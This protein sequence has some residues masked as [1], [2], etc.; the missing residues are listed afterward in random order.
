MCVLPGWYWSRLLLRNAGRIERLTFSIGLSLAL[1]PAALAQVRMLNTGVTLVIA[2]LSV[3][4][5]L[6][7]GFAAWVAFGADHKRKETLSAPPAPLPFGSLIALGLALV[8]VLAGDA[9]SWRAFRYT[10]YCWGWIS[11]KCTESGASQHFLILVA[12]LLT[13]AGAWYFVA[14]RRV[15]AYAG[16]T[17]EYSQEEYPGSEDQRPTRKVRYL[18]PAV[19]ALVLV[20]GYLGPV[21]YDW[22]FIR[23]VDQYSHAVMSNLMLSRGQ[24]YPYLIYPPGFHTL[25]AVLSRLSGL[26]PL[27]LYTVLAPALLILPALSCYVLARRLW[28][29]EVGVGAAFFAGLVAC[30]PYFYFNDAMYPNIVGAEFLLVLT[31]AALARLYARP[32]SGSVLLVAVLGSSVVLYHQV[33]SLYEAALLGLIGLLFLPY[34]L[35]HDR[36]RGFA[37][38]ASFVILGALSLL[39][40]WNT[41]DLPGTIASLFGG[42]GKNSTDTAMGMAIGSQAPF[43]LDY[44]IGGI[45]SQPVFWLGFL[46]AILASGAAMLSTDLAQKLSTM[47]LVLWVLLMA[48]GSSTTLDGFPERFG[49][50]LGVPLAIFAAF[51]LVAIMRSISAI[52]GT[53]ALRIARIAVI[54]I[55]VLIVVRVVQNFGQAAVPSWR[56]TMTPEIAA[57]GEWLKDHNTGGNIMVSPQ[58]TQVPSRMMLAMGQYSGMQ[59]YTKHNILRNRDLPPTGPGPLYD[60]LWVMNHPTGEH[61][62]RLLQK[63]RV[64]YIVLYKYMPDRPVTN[65]WRHFENQSSQYRVAFQ[66][67]DV[68]IVAPR[69]SLSE[70]VWP[71][72]GE[73][74][75][76]DD[77]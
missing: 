34:L 5:V 17:P 3:A 70:T 22:P 21:L 67:S 59:S 51:A 73:H 46:G 19:L 33:S 28:G 39:Y 20:R 72:I 49:R 45:V 68:L 55:A 37:L 13:L 4:F 30:G 76:L 71:K 16:P 65:Y 40:A 66:N 57:A 8:L 64:R 75:I 26:D 43:H 42:S 60:V 48:A 36:K 25:T 23:G 77:A 14:S 62:K 6:G 2:V 15:G 11:K 56:L 32:S 38:L 58:K 53:L 9:W 1:I 47:T 29:W 69:E 61:T 12:L 52:R 31:I 27:T 50:D 35:L 74:Q 18:L 63:Y 54:L 44:L 10:A 24:I 41:Y 7:A